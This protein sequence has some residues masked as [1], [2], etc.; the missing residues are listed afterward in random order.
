MPHRNSLSYRDQSPKPTLLYIFP[1]RIRCKLLLY[2]S[3]AFSS[4]SLADLNCPSKNLVPHRQHQLEQALPEHTDCDTRTAD[5]E[6][7]SQATKRVGTVCVWVWWWRTDSHHRR[8]RWDLIT[9]LRLVPDKRLWPISGRRSLD[10]SCFC[11]WCGLLHHPLPP[12]C[13]TSPEPSVTVVLDTLCFR[14]WNH[15]CRK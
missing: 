4:F 8:T 14:W 6:H 10:T 11:V 5:L 2:P 12:C 3:K 13:D 7:S 15:G 1:F 9:G